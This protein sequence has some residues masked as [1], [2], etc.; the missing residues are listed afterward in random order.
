VWPSTDAGFRAVIESSPDGIVIHHEGVIVYANAAMARMLEFDSPEALHG[1]PV[2]ERVHPDDHPQTFERI[3][4]LNAGE[5]QVPFVEVHLLHR[6]NVT[7][8]HCSVIGL[9]LEFQGKP[10]VVAVARD[11]TEQRRMQTRLVEAER[12]V[13]LGTL[14]AGIAHEINN[15]L[16][17]LGLHLESVSGM[18]ERL[19]DMVDGE[20]RELVER[21]SGSL[22]IA[23]DGAMR[24][25]DIVRD[26][27]VFARISDDEQTFVDLRAVVR[28]AVTM[29]AH[30]LR[31]RADVVVELDDLPLVRGS[32]GRLTQVV[33]NLLLNAAHAVG[34]G[35]AEHQ[36]VTIRGWSD[37][38]RVNVSVADTGHGIA[39]ELVPRIFEPF[40]TTK[41]VGDGSGLGLAIVHG[42]VTAHGG[43]VDVTS[44]PGAGATFVVSLPAAAQ[45][46]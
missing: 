3:R 15:P 10:F 16:T 8:S 31:Q 37:R 19:R 24:V 5:T 46:P 20:A 13:A 44:A 34:I 17:Y 2:I 39:A 14:S 45:Q 1:T 28:R 42:I 27:G 6:D 9:R 21:L 26:L 18:V 11:I 12:M 29:T 4:R 40:F 25:R 32:D 7:V 35:D 38:A 33:V 22:A 30:E 41:S 36:R 23:Q 43:T